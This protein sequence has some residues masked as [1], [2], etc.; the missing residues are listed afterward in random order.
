MNFI[1]EKI[2]EMYNGNIGKGVMIKKLF[3]WG[4]DKVSKG[5][6]DYNKEFMN[7]KL[8][9][10]FS[11]TISTRY[12]NFRPNNNEKVI[13]ELLNEEDDEKKCYFTKLFDL[14]FLDCVKHFMKQISIKELEGLEL[15]EDIKKDSKILKNN[16]DDE[17]YL[18]CLED[19]LTRYDEILGRKKSRKREKKSGLQGQDDCIKNDFIKIIQ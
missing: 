3:T 1:N 7:E 13:L 10:I 16:I 17:E 4:G 14:S 11:Y 12:N 5:K 8:K 15:Y 18:K 9:D 2:E 6:I 19:H